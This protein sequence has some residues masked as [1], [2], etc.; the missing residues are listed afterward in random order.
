MSPTAGNGGAA[1]AGDR[2]FALLQ[3]C[4]PTRWLSTLIQRIANIRHTAFKNALIRLFLRGYT[5][6]LKES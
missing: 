6:D 2:L 3:L 5:V 1:S 4:L